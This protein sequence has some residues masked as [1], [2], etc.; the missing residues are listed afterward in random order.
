M[1]VLLIFGALSYLYFTKCDSYCHSASKHACHCDNYPICHSS[2]TSA[3]KLRLD[4]NQL[5][6][7]QGLPCFHPDNSGIFTPRSFAT[8]F[9]FS[10]HRFMRFLNFFLSPLYRTNRQ[11][12]II[13]AMINT[14]YAVQNLPN[15]VILRSPLLPHAYSAH[16]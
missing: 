9:C 6:Q 5:L 14:K 8:V 3:F 2:V 12:S 10:F 1:Q 16:A 15:L 7:I 4:S 13:T 11:T